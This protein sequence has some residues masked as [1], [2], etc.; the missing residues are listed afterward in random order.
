MKLFQARPTG[1]RPGTGRAGD[2]GGAAWS[3]SC[4]HQ[5]AATGSGAGASTAGAGRGRLAKPDADRLEPAPDVAV[6]R[7]GAQRDLL[8]ERPL[9]RVEDER[10]GL[11]AT[12]A[13]VRADQ[14]L[15]CRHFAHDR[16]V[17]AEQEEIRRMGHRIL[18]LQAHDRMRAED[19]RRILT[20]DPVLVEV[21]HGRRPEGDG[22]VRSPSGPSAAQLR[23]VRRAAR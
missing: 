14:L 20:F 12:K 17:H 16:V 5:V 7:R 9:G 3:R 13:T 19:R 23:D 6:D 2:G 10:L 4:G 15:E 8:V 18:A 22:A 1:T 11:R 21:A